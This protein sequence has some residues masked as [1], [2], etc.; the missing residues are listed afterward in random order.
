MT[1]YRTALVHRAMTAALMTRT[2][3]G[4][5]L[6]E[7]VCVFDI[8]KELGLKV[9]FDHLETKNFEGIYAPSINQITLE[10]Q[11][12]SLRQRFTCAH[13]VG[14]FVL[15]HGQ[16]PN[17]VSLDGAV[18]H[19]NTPQEEFLANVFASFL[20]M[21]KA[22]VLTAFRRHGVKLTDATAIDFYTVASALGVGFSTL[23]NHCAAY[24]PTHVTRAQADDALKSGKRLSE[25]RAEI[26][27]GILPADELKRI[28][29]YT[30]TSCWRRPVDLIAADGS[31]LGD[32]AKFDF[33]LL[34][35]PPTLS[36]IGP[37]CFRAVREGTYPLHGTGWTGLLR[38]YTPTKGGLWKVRISGD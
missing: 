35:P 29:V 3:L 37:R 23:V 4:H 7:P 16:V 21:P 27:D 28:V 13:E 30:V 38:C 8:A 10:P 33:D 14:H 34:E 32:I 17:C 1:P 5:S 6:D 26:I 24:I 25:I 11:R 12:P 22:A 20:L 31:A 9:R 18:T 19:T 15:K 36:A 2:E